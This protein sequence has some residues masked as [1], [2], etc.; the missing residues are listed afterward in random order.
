MT[1]QL[2]KRITD[3]IQ[4]QVPAFI[5]D[6]YPTFVTFIEAYYEWMESRIKKVDS[7]EYGSKKLLSYSDVDKTIPEFMQYFTN[8]FLIHIPKNVLCDKV[9]LLK[10][11][12]KFYQSRGTE[13]SYSL[14]FR[15]LFEDE[16]NF[17]YPTVDILRCDSGGWVQDQSIRCK[18]PSNV[19]PFDI[20]ETFLYKRIYGVVSGAEAIVN[21]IIVHDNNGSYPVY[22]MFFE[23]LSLT[24]NFDPF[25]RIVISVDNFNQ[26]Q[27][28]P[29]LVDIQLNSPG[30]DYTI[31]DSIT[32][33]N[34]YGVNM[35][36]II[37]EVEP[38]TGK[39]KE[40]QIIDPSSGYPIYP[41]DGSL[42]VHFSDK[43]SLTAIGFPILGAVFNY[44]GYY[45]DSNGFLDNIK[46]LRDDYFYQEFSYQIISHSNMLQWFA[47]VNKLLHPAGT[48]VFGKMLIEPEAIFAGLAATSIESK[49]MSVDNILTDIKTTTPT[50]TTISEPKMASRIKIGP[51]LRS[52]NRD[53]FRYPP[54]QWN[55]ENAAD[56]YWANYANYSLADLADIL[57]E[58]I[59]SKDYKAF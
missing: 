12:K 49:F 34:D 1:I 28:L 27:I 16:P 5:R 26:L 40:I 42:E 37:R 11:I 21:N 23:K 44:S 56:P 30:E 54:S 19:Q 47:V 35:T 45:S 2:D 18:L 48:I 14:L 39:I 8:E 15:I 57:L 46:K 4:G 6:D 38:G 3:L 25:E 33:S 50:I 52:F 9:K 24:G 53:A 59:I 36:A 43:G 13:K 20:I 29:I 7:P 22:E 55:S 58:D 17:Y 31:S 32:I 10:N 41:A 51:T